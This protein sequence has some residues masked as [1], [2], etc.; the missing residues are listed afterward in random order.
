[1]PAK[2]V[3]E[4]LSI[5]HHC[6]SRR[7]VV[8]EGGLRVASGV[9]A[10]KFQ[11]MSS[12]TVVVEGQKSHVP[13]DAGEEGGG[14]EDDDA[15]KDDEQ[16]EVDATTFRSADAEGHGVVGTCMM[17]PAGILKGDP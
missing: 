16:D 10:G 1:M 17:Q 12:R 3:E 2:I 8:E 6:S 15:T 13:D 14:G 5:V 7:Q 4:L 11:T 9:A